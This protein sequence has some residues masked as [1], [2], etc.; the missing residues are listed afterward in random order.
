MRGQ[1]CAHVAWRENHRATKRM[2]ALRSSEWLFKNHWDVILLKQFL[3]CI[4]AEQDAEV[5]Q[6]CKD[7]LLGVYQLKP[8][9]V[10]IHHQLSILASEA[11]LQEASAQRL[12]SDCE[13]W[14]AESIEEVAS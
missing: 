3:K 7:A 10:V 2:E 8:Y 6:E 14:L 9:C 13:D 4:V 11:D 1:G 5:M 12:I